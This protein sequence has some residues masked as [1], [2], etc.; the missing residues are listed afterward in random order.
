MIWSVSW[1]NVW[2]SKIRSS[3]VIVAFV[4]GIFGGLFTVAVYVGMVDQRVK[5]AIG[6]EASHIQIHDPGYLDN[7]ELNYTIDDFSY[8][9]QTLENLPYIVAYSPRIKIM[10]MASTSGN[11]SGIIINGIDVEK[12]RQVSGIANSLV[13]GGGTFFNDSN[14]TRQK[15]IVVGE[16]L[17]KT[18]KLAYFMISDK[19]MERMLNNQKLKKISPL[20]DTLKNVRYRS[21]KDF[22]A[23]L[24]SVLGVKATNKYIFWIKREVIK[25]KL[26]QKIV[27]S[28]QALDG[29]IAFDAFRITGVYKTANAVFDGLNVYVRNPDIMPVANLE[30]NQFNEI[31][32]LLSSVKYDDRTVSEIK[33]KFP[34]LSIQTWDEILPEA[35]IYSKT[36]N[37]YLFIFMGII[38]CHKL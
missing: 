30:E 32:I 7:N 9:E 8:L 12:E 28:F 15:P 6:N 36:M 1:K 5:L 25:Y 14:D 4:F 22:E 31:A 27:L 18:L 3:V 23:A 10:G 13:D 29:H 11:A 16:K 2:R 21:E 37:F 26:N 24:V 19:D 20:L 33:S 38:L 34:N 35:G 17:A